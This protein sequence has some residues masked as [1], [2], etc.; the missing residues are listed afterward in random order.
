MGYTASNDLTIRIHDIEATGLIL[1]KAVS[2]GINNVMNGIQFTNAAIQKNPHEIFTEARQAAVRDAKT[3]AETIVAEL[4]V[5]LGN[6]HSITEGSN[7]NRGN[8]LSGRGMPEMA[9]RSA[10][11]DSTS[12]PIASGENSYSVSV[13]IR[14]EIDQSSPSCSDPE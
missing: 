5:K 4:G 8:N 13:D 14:W 9:M 1:D 7:S 6:I 3:K 12:V 2:L 11:A 10:M